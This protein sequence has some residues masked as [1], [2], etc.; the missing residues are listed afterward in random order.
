MKYG[1]VAA[2]DKTTA[3]AAMEILKD[4]GNAFDA[5]VCAVFTSMISEYTLTGAC[6]GG[7]F[8]HIQKIRYR[9][10]STFSYTHLKIIRLRI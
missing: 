7:V 2:G 8:W 5:A 6:G 4:G 3:N 10:F 1:S 9:Q